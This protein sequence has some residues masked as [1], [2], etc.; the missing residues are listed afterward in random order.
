[1]TVWHEQRQLNALE[2]ELTAS[3]P[4]LAGML[5]IFSRLTEGERPCGM[6]R[7]PQRGGHLR[8][9]LAQPGI[10][11][12]LALT[13]IVMSGMLLAVLASPGPRQC[14]GRAMTSHAP[15]QAGSASAPY[16]GSRSLVPTVG[17]CPVYITKR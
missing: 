2:A 7:F 17:G 13:V 9:F 3:A 16:A 1:M 8:S 10:V 6:E 15:A 14:P 12:V 4:R 5:R 11:G